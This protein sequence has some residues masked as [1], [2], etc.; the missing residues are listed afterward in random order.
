MAE[1][2]M[3]VAVIGGGYAGLAAAVMLARQNIPVTLFEASKT[4]GGRAR[5]I[6][7]RGIAMDNGQHILL[8]AYAQ[9]LTLIERL[10]AASDVLWRLPLTLEQ[11]GEFRLACPRLP[12]PLRLVTGLLAADGLTWPEKWSAARW[13]HRQIHGGNAPVTGTVSELTQAQP[14]KLRRLLWH[15]LCVSALNTPPQEASAQ[16][17]R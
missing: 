1:K 14:E 17:F 8:G 6:S 9:T 13:A 15:P 12:A 10:Q 7:Y 5:G 3:R 16:V 2:L 11:P 4:L